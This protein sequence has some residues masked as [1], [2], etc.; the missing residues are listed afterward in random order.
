[1]S[2]AGLDR[3]FDPRALLAALDR[4]RVDYIVVG[5][6]ARIIHGTPELTDELDIV[7]SLKERNLQRLENAL[8][9]LAPGAG[10][11]VE[12]LKETPEP[13]LRVATAHGTLTLVPEPA[14]T[15]GYDDLKRTAG[16]EHLGQGLRPQVASTGDLGRMLNTL[17]RPEDRTKLRDLRRVEDLQISRGIER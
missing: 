10:P 4:H 13:T 6:L 8:T 16:R 1:M 5:A 14:G 11:T 9:E 2:S 17:N 15:R 12:Q 7:P 3:N